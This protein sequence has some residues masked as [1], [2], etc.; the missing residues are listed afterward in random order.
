[1]TGFYIY[2]FYCL[3]MSIVAF[4]LMKIDKK[5]SIKHRYRI[6]ESTLIWVAIL[7]GSVGE[8]IGMYSFRHKTKH[9]KFYIGLPLILF[10]QCMILGLVLYY[11][12]VPNS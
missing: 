10:I 8:I 11:K 7:G 3:I 1:M 12:Y 5:K 9:K 4:N 6:K 2:V